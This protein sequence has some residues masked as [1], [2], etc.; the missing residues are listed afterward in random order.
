MAAYYAHQSLR[1]GLDLL[2]WL[3]ATTTASVIAG[4]ADAAHRIQDSAAPGADPAVYARRL[5]DWLAVTD[6][7]WLVVLDD[8]TEPRAFDGWWPPVSRTGT[9]W[10]LVTTRSR[11]AT[12]S[13]AGRMVVAVDVYEP[14]ESVSYLRDRL[15]L[16]AKAGLLDNEAGALAADLGHLPLALAYATAY[17]INEQLTCGE[18]RAM[19]LDRRP[20]LD[21]ILPETADTEGYGRQIAT[22]LLLSL[23]AAQAGAPAGVVTRAVRLAAMLDPAGHP[24]ALWRTDAIRSY[25]GDGRPIA[26]PEAR[27]AVAV[28]HRYAMITFEPGARPRAIRIHALTARA[29]REAFDSDAACPLADALLTLWPE[30]DHLD[31]ELAAV[32]RANTEVLIGL[33]GDA[34]WRPEAHPLLFRAGLSFLEA[35]LNATALR[36]WLATAERAMRKLGAKHPMTLRALTN[37]AACYRET[38]R[39]DTAI[40]LLERV[41]V[42]R[43]QV[44]G[45]DADTLSSR[46]NLAVAYR[47]DGRVA[48][49]ID[50][51]EDVVAESGRVLGSDS[52]D[53]L[54][55]TANLAWCYHQHSRNADARELLER[56]LADSERIR[57]WRHPDTLR[58]RAWLAASYWRA[59]RQPEA[60]ALQERVLA[61]CEVVLGARHPDT[62]GARAEL[63][64]LYRQIGRPGDAITLQ[65]SVV[66]DRGQI[67]GSDHPDTL[68]ARADLDAMRGQHGTDGQG[69]QW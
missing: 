11:D 44:L 15:T 57:G 61:E 27:K 69:G 45:D 60:I 2:L 49:A 26:F 64:A 20:Q 43:G 29:I 6:R 32:L 46:A 28:L 25:L 16:A 24:E 48:D 31:R 41:L 10:T 36:Y 7:S 13:G 9:G 58:I 35:G 21:Q 50:L 14:T 33:N 55:A 51:L 38:G 18:Y 40:T 66:I 56:V 17:M 54:R 3:D 39:I 67:L 47:E 12:I 52:P 5:L 42:H 59:G 53:T 4:Y 22:T 30:G 68:R 8:M 37:L 23:D 63:A 1:D 19:L 65:E 62:V 34:L